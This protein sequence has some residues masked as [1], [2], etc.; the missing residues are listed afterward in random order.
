MNIKSR[1]KRK[2]LEKKLSPLKEKI[3][4]HPLYDF[5]KE[6]DAVIV[7]MENHIF[8]VWDFQSLLKSLQSKLTCTGTP[9]HPTSD[10]EARR[11]INEIV[12]DEE[13]GRNPQGGYS[14]H[15]ELYREAMIDAGANTSKIDKLIY[16]I[17]Q[18]ADIR[19]NSNYLL[20]HNV[21]RFVLHTFENIYQNNLIDLLSIFTY[22]R[23]DIIPK[24]F[25]K[26]IK[27]FY[28]DN[29]S[30]WSKLNFYLNEHIECDDI[31]HGPMAKKILENICKDDAK[32]WHRAE[33]ASVNALTQRKLMWDNI[34]KSIKKLRIVSKKYKSVSFA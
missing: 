16:E 30:R 9:W 24:M 12:L 8:S 11:L 14:S 18:G 21:E 13:S 7:F 19:S 26:L 32:K 28:E 15:F 29:P 5:M 2:D 33:T 6:E 1:S 4:T 34:L 20:P 27:K 23:E 10:R 3:V 25:S 31:R 22:G 17:S